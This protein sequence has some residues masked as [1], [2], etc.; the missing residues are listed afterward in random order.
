LGITPE[1]A[2]A[3]AILFQYPLMDRLGFWG[4]GRRQQR[5]AAGSFSIR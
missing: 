4:R 2:S 5:V 3:V 1:I